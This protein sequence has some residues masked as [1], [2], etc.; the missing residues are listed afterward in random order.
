MDNYLKWLGYEVCNVRAGEP[1]IL[2]AKP[3]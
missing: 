2:V 3:L 1:A